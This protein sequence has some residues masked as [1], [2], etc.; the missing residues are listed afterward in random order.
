MSSNFCKHCGKPLENEANFCKHCGGTLTDTVAPT[1]EL[2]ATATPAQ[3]PPIQTEPPKKGGNLMKKLKTFA[4]CLFLICLALGSGYIGSRFFSSTVVEEAPSIQVEDGVS[5]SEDPQNTPESPEQE[6]LTLETPEEIQLIEEEA[7]S[8][9]SKT[10]EELIA[11][12]WSK[13]I[14]AG[15][16]T[17]QRLILREDGTGTGT[18]TE[19]IFDLTEYSMLSADMDTGDSFELTWTME[20]NTITTSTKAY[21]ATQEEI[22]LVDTFTYYPEED[23]LVMETYEFWHLGKGSTRDFFRHE[24]EI[25]EGY[26]SVSS[27]IAQNNGDT[28]ALI[29]KIKGLWYLDLLEWNYNEDG[30]GFIYI[31]KLGSS[32]EEIREFTWL[33][34]PQNGDYT[35]NNFLVASDFGTYSTHQWVQ[36]YDNG[37]IMYSRA[38]SFDTEPI[39]F[40]RYFDV[41]NMDYT[42]S[43]FVDMYS[44]FFG[45]PS[46]VIGGSISPGTVLDLILDIF[47]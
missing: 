21:T 29:N 16:G 31:P 15:G 40:T 7:N 26:I 47:G 42:M 13:F 36:F 27:W 41:T 5:P 44:A 14:L 11:G 46:N 10:Q 37:Q 12:V 45:G 32:P 35:S 23:M 30:T 18:T 3:T 4:C 6:A 25:P 33:I 2:V 39:K 34:L 22:Y 38:D 9:A 24:P 8:L 43:A 19:Y 20:G 28:V 1:Q 17:M